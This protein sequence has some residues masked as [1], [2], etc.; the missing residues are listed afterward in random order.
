ME[1]NYVGRLAWDRF[2]S[3]HEPAKRAERPG[4][5]L[6]DEFWPVAAVGT[7]CRAS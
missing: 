3:R 1:A 5:L 7:A 6:V 4:S 2:V